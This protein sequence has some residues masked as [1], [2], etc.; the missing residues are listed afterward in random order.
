MRC[1]LTDIRIQIGNIE[2]K[3][4]LFTASGTFGYGND[5]PDFVDVSKLGVSLQSLSHYIP[6][7]EIHPLESWKHLP[8]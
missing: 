8:V 5:V 2:F 1:A 4:P 3:N 6:G 7:K